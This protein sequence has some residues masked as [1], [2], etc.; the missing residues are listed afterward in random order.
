MI[1]LWLGNVLTREIDSAFLQFSCDFVGLLHDT[2]DG[3]L[4]AQ[5]LVLQAQCFS[6]ARGTLSLNS[7]EGCL[8]KQVF[9]FISVDFLE[10]L[11]AEVHGKCFFGSILL[12]PEAEL[13]VGEFGLSHQSAVRNEGVPVYFL[14]LS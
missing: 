2:H 10:L 11:F 13:N 3:C 12:G 14:A 4:V 8:L 1:I 5:D 9:G 7:H 6:L